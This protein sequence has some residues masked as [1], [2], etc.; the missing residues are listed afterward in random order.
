MFPYIKVKLKK[1]TNYCDECFKFQTELKRKDLDQE[2]KNKVSE[3]FAR[4]LFANCKASR[5]CCIEF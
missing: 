4:S 1:K 3:L 5:I 2:E